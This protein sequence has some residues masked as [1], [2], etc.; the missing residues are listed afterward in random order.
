MIFQ[1]LCKDIYDIYNFARVYMI[2]CNF[3]GVYMKYTH[4]MT[5]CIKIN[6]LDKN[7]FRSTHLTR[8]NKTRFDLLSSPVDPPILI[9]IV[10]ST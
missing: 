10:V 5:L 4:D 7:C 1:L 6:F 9:R 2:F 8:N 3:V